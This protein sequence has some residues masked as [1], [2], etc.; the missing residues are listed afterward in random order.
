MREKA[1]E[2]LTELQDCPYRMLR[3]L[4]GLKTDNKEVQGGRY[5]K[6]MMEGC[7]SV[8]GEGGKI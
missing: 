7:I 1:E 4:K 2:V 3:L 8:R 6:E 5:M